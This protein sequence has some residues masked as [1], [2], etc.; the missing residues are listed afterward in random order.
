MARSRKFTP[1]LWN[2]KRYDQ[3][4][5]GAVSPWA[6]SIF[7]YGTATWGPWKETYDVPDASDI[8]HFL[9]KD[10]TVMPK[11]SALGPD[12]RD[13]LQNDFRGLMFQLEGLGS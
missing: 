1:S 6:G 13:F 5:E 10:T 11:S 12:Q 3:L 2:R 8:R 7:C 9:T 4:E